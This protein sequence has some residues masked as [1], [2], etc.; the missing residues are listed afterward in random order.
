MIAAELVGLWDSRPYDYGSMESYSLAF[1]ADGNGW[2]TYENAAGGISV[3]RFTWTC[4]EV[5]VVEVRY[6]TTISGSW[7][8]GRA[9]LA[10]IDER[11]PDDTVVLTG[12]SI[13]EDLTPMATEPFTALHLEHPIEFGR[14]FGLVRRDI[15][16]EDG[17]AFGIGDA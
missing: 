1:R 8:P 13:G 5:G 14:N 9:G 12:Y 3:G 6:S 11:G 2:S 7:E 17:P 10:T 4:P 16:D 15:H